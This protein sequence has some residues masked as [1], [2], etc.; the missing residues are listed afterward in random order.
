VAIP[1]AVTVL[2]VVACPS[3][4]ITHFAVV[5]APC[6]NGS[7]AH[8]DLSPTA[9]LAFEVGGLMHVAVNTAMNTS[10]GVSGG[11]AV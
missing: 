8:S 1:E 3:A 7:I 9:S 11:E 4:P 10:Y 5:V 6:M 2:Y